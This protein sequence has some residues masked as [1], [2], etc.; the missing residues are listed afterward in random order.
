E[1]LVVV[2]T[3]ELAIQVAEARGQLGRHRHLVA[4]PVYGGQPY[5]RQLRAL[6]RGVQV[7]VGTPGRLLDHLSRGTLVLDQVRTAILDEADEMLNMG[8]VEDIEK[9][10]EDRKSGG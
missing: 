10:L 8:F 6:A 9:L 3:G 7:I 2:P 4:L 1:A 5:D